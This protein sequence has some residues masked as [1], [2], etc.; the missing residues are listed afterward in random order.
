MHT[1]DLYI[2]GSLVEF[3]ESPKI[4]YNYKLTDLEAPL[5]VSNGYSKTVTVPGTKNN[6]QLFDN[7][8]KVER[9]QNIGAAFNPSKKAPFEI[10]VDGALYESGYAKLDTAKRGDD[11]FWEYG[12]TLYSGLGEFLYN[13]TYG[14]DGSKLKLSDLWFGAG[15]ASARDTE[16]DFEITR[17]EIANAWNALGSDS[18]ITWDDQ[19][20]QVMN[21]VPC[22]NGKPKDFDTKKVA[23]NMS[24]TPFASAVTADG[25][26]YGLVGSYALGELNEEIDE[27]GMR[28]LRDWL[29]RPCLRMKK[30]V[31]A[32]AIPSNN[33]GNIGT[34][35]GGYE[36]YLDT[37][38]FNS[39]N[40]YWEDTWL[41][42]PRLDE[43]DY[44]ASESIEGQFAFSSST[45][46]GSSS[47]QDNPLVITY[48]T[49]ID[50]SGQT[51]NGGSVSFKLK[52]HVTGGTLTNQ[53]TS[54][55]TCTYSTNDQGQSLGWKTLTNYSSA[56]MVQLVGYN[57][58]GAA[59]AGSDIAFI[60]N[61]WKREKIP[62]HAAGR[63]YFPG[64]DETIYPE[65]NDFLKYYTPAYASNNTGYKTFYTDFVGSWSTHD[66]LSNDNFVLTIDSSDRVFTE[67]KLVITK[68]VSQYGINKGNGRGS[69]NYIHQETKAVLNRLMFF[70]DRSNEDKPQDAV[71][72]Y[73][74]IDYITPELTQ[75]IPTKDGGMGATKFTSGKSGVGSGSFITKKNLLNTKYTPADYLL[76]YCKMFGLYII[77]DPNKRKIS[78]LTRKNFYKRDV[79]DNIEKYL[80]H[81]R[82]WSITP[83][84]FDTKY[85]DFAPSVVEGEFAK[86]YS[87]TTSM[88]FGIQRVDTGYEFNADVNTITDKLCFKSCV[89]AI[90]KSPYYSVN[91]GG[92]APRTYKLWMR[93]GFKYTLFGTGDTTH[94][95][96]VQQAEM[97]LASI[98]QNPSHK[99]YDFTP[100]PQFKDND[101]GVA[102]DNVLLFYNGKKS[103]TDNI[104]PFKYYLTSDLIFMN[105]YNNGKYCWLYTASEFDGDGEQ[106]ANEVT[107]LP[108]FERYKTVDNSNNILLS[109]DFGTP[110]QLYVPDYTETGN[111]TIYT[112]YWK[113][114]FEDMY[115]IDGKILNCY[116]LIKSAPNPEMFRKFY[117]FQN[118]IWRLNKVN[119]WVPGGLEPTQCEFIKVQDV[120][121]YTTNRLADENSVNI[122][123]SKNMIPDTG[124]TINATI[125]TSAPDVPWTLEVQMQ[126]VD[127]YTETIVISPTAGTGS[128]V[129][130]ITVP[131]NTTEHMLNFMAI[132]TGPY[133]SA[134]KTFTQL[135]EYDW[136]VGLPQDGCVIGYTDDLSTFVNVDVINARVTSASC[137]TAN[138]VGWGQNYV[139]LNFDDNITLGFV[140]HTVNITATTTN[141]EQQTLVY[142][143]CQIPEKLSYPASGATKTLT[144]NIP[145]KTTGPWWLQIS[146]NNNTH[147]Y[148]ATENTDTVARSSGI[149]YSYGTTTEYGIVEQGKGTGKFFTV[150]P[151][152]LYFVNHGGTQY[153]NITT[154]SAWG[155]T[156]PSWV[157]AN[158]TT[159]YGN[160]VIAFTTDTYAGT[161]DRVGN[162]IINGD[163]ASATIP[164]TQYRNY[165]GRALRVATDV[166]VVPAEGGVVNIN[167]FYNNR[168]SDTVT[169]STTTP[170]VVFGEVQWYGESGTIR[171]VVP[172][173]SSART[174]TF[175]I[176]P[177]SALASAVS[178]SV[179]Q[180]GQGDY[181]I[182]SKDDI[183]FHY[184]GGTDSFTVST[185]NDFEIVLSV[186][187]E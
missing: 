118:T 6:N 90:E 79:I 104:V 52:V 111:D 128:A 169:P 174:I 48:T 97:D 144:S 33:S 187:G 50:T 47:E 164:V 64:S 40:P 41:T 126:H 122:K 1:V 86:D 152:A 99:Y 26:T 77:K 131:A 153:V 140:N 161:S 69:Q 179:Q 127:N 184:D 76:S 163:G 59:V 74:V 88:G 106:I 28:D 108:V 147:V 85:F 120:N 17:D 176:T 112:R 55:N 5:D 58:Y 173:S 83:L 38:F 151:Q 94:Q 167:V 61:L 157:T 43:I 148:T 4:P 159:G 45:E 27:W 21:F 168:N 92:D 51:L 42:L 137:A 150:S 121:N 158:T 95:E 63:G 49:D 186:Y 178:T 71:V 11:G 46:T 156:T 149:T 110:R 84:T 78:I 91:P 75:T 162:I 19:R 62:A 125:T 53:Q 73:G 23:L 105:N 14:G 183:R 68:V 44:T 102:G 138:Y 70:T 15:A 160:A 29:Q 80:D 96:E 66:Y 135:S 139:E 141:G 107:E 100:K 54:I 35:E 143:V 154:N 89:E 98:N 20:H 166:S 32:C 10:Y 113:T 18:D 123:L 12:L 9:T 65:F 24:T 136:Y 57:S 7:I 114:Y 134:F 3:S 36:V 130:S 2:N 170:G 129:C 60:T 180:T 8:W 142:K 165:T 115:D 82:D 116:M 119:N 117:W 25:Q 22:Y 172:A 16:L 109:L 72:K 37:D 124:A 87:A 103:T 101:S 185:N 145:L 31:E 81:G 34:T 181:L 13:L 177:G 155:I 39:T 171:A 30:I 133:N 175:T 56:I 182:T 132:V 93:N 67:L 146:D